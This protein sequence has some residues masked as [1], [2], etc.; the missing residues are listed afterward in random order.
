M[1]F[2]YSL[3]IPSTLSDFQVLDGLFQ[4]RIDGRPEMNFSIEATS[5]LR[6]WN[7]ILTTND[8]DGSFLFRDPASAAVRNRIYRVQMLP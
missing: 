7:T 6:L 3:V 5:N 4:F 2:N 8:A 1:Q